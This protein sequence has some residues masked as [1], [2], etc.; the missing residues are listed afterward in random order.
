MWSILISAGCGQK[1]MQAVTLGLFIYLCMYVCIHASHPSMASAHVFIQSFTFFCADFSIPPPLWT[2]FPLDRYE[3]QEELKEC[4][5]EMKAASTR[6]ALL[7]SR[8]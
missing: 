8:E 5:E 7:Q 3:C 4:K 2:C 1:E 6:I